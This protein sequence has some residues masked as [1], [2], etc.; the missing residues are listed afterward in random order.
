MMEIY[1]VVEHWRVYW[2]GEIK[3]HVFSTYS[4]AK[5]F[6]DKCIEKDTSTGISSDSFKANN[7]EF[8]GKCFSAEK[9]PEKQYGLEI[10][11]KPEDNY[12]LHWWA[13]FG[14]ENPLQVYSIYHIEKQIIDEEEVKIN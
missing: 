10:A 1:I 7:V 9:E 13:W 2:E 6:Y 11:N 4:K 12:Y 3:V 5:D 14:K 8:C